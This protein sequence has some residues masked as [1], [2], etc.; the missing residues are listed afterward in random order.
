MHEILVLLLV[1]FAGIL[2]MLG[3]VKG[4]IK[5]LLAAFILALLGSFLRTIPIL[6]YID[7]PDYWLLAIIVLG[8]AGIWSFIKYTNHRRSYQEWMSSDEKT[9]L[10][11]RL[12]KD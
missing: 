10:K 5:L 1:V 4:G 8:F 3:A 6:H 11:R 7:L 2:I 12:E 9:S